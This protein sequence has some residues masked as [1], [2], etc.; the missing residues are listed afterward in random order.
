MGILKSK[1]LVN[2]LVIKLN[3]NFRLRRLGTIFIF[4]SVVWAASG[5][6]L[7]YEVVRGSKKLGDMTVKRTSLENQTYYEIESKVTFRI[8]FSFVVDYESTSEYKYGQL[9]KEYTHN[10]LSGKT[11]KKST[12]WWDGQVYTLDLDGSRIK[13]KQPINYSVAAVYYEEPEDQKKVYSPQFGEYLIF[14]KIKDHVYELESPDG[15]NEYYYTHGVCTE[16]KV[17]RDFAKFSFVMTP[18]SLAAVESKKIVGG[19][20]VVD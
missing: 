15:R 8:L 10:Q 12:I 19:G 16:V 1:R 13:V 9:I 17:F 18:E 5:Q 6:V 14:K 3:E 7:N 11:Q 4:M 20:F 2:F